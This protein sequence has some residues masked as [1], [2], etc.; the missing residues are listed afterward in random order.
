MLLELAEQSIQLLKCDISRWRLCHRS[1]KDNQSKSWK[2]VWSLFFLSLISSHAIST[3]R[4]EHIPSYRGRATTSFRSYHQLKTWSLLSKDNQSKS[5]E[6]V[7]ANWNCLSLVTSHVVGNSRAEHT[8][9][10]MSYKQVKTSSSYTTRQPIQVLK[11]S[12]TSVFLSLITSHAISSSRAEHT[13][14]YRGRATTSFISY[15]HQLKTWALLSKDSQSKSWEKVWEKCNCLSLVTS[16][17]VGTNKAEHTTSYMSYKQM[18]ALSS[19]TTRQPIQVLK[20]SLT[21]VFF[22]IDHFSRH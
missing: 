19:F 3:G 6:K 17:V 2:K 18:K 5:W 15:H 4:A 12:V 7:W 16:Q 9:S 1:P 10:Y 21:S 14:S 22:V 11:K 13:T 20:K 8:I